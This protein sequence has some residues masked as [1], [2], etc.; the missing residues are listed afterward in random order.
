M[1]QKVKKVWCCGHSDTEDPRRCRAK[2]RKRTACQD[3]AFAWAYRDPVVEHWDSECRKCQEDQIERQKQY[4]NQQFVEAS[5]AY[6]RLRD[7]STHDDASRRKSGR[8]RFERSNTASEIVVPTGWTSAQNRFPSNANEYEQF[9][10]GRFNPLQQL[11]DSHI[12]PQL[13]GPMLYE[14]PRPLPPLDAHHSQYRGESQFQPHPHVF[15]NYAHNGVQVYR[16][17]APPPGYAAQIPRNIQ[18]AQQNIARHERAQITP[19]DCDMR[20]PVI[21]DDADYPYVDFRGSDNKQPRVGSDG[22]P[23]YTRHDQ[24]K[25]WVPPVLGPLPPQQETDTAPPSRSISRSPSAKPGSTR[26]LP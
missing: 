23:S 5:Q 21:L 17:R 9:V 6:P 22:R 18:I 11:P 1:C 16:S 8:P 2:N 25:G 4:E 19:P 24:R 13:P 15:T 7:V 10:R 20:G 14:G 12:P 3:Y 26:S